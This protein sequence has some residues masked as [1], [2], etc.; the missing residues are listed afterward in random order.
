MKRLLV[1]SLAFAAMAAGCSKGNIKGGGP[2]P[3]Q[4][5]GQGPG[6][7]N[8]GPGAGTSGLPTD[9][10]PRVA[11]RLSGDQVHA[12]LLELTGFVYRGPAV[13]DDP[14]AVWGQSMVDDADLLD[15]YSLA[16]GRPDY[17]YVVRENLEPGVSFA[18]MVEDGARSTCR[19]AADAEVTQHAPP[20]GVAHLLLKASSTDSLP[21][22]EAAVRANVASL[23]LRFWGEPLSPDDDEVTALLDVFRAGLAGAPSATTA[24]AWRAVCIALAIHPK[25]YVY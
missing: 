8:P 15:H 20:G 3:G 22:Q 7:I 25:F 19:Q 1:I 14:N 11:R 13:V 21:G 17:N 18:K 9:A 2:G 16:L 12:A 6:V 10:T 23:A 24:D 4:G 5:P